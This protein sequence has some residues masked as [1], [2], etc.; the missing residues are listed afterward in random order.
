MCTDKV[1]CDFL[2]PNRANWILLFFLRHKMSLGQSAPQ[3]ALARFLLVAALQL[4]YCVVVFKY[5]KVELKFSHVCRFQNHT[6]V[7]FSPKQPTF[8][9]M[10]LQTK[11]YHMTPSHSHT[12]MHISIIPPAVHK[13]TCSPPVTHSDSVSLTV[14]SNSSFFYRL[15][16][17]FIAVCCVALWAQILAGRKEGTTQLLPFIAL[18]HFNN[19]A[20][21]L[22]WHP[23][24]I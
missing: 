20:V 24:A 23:C 9:C 10:H 19:G 7:H 15:T 5:G 14:Q 17:W 1:K 2:N 3:L 6:W 4:K 21:I 13:N 16:I 22:K 12:N 8:P 11:T 18:F